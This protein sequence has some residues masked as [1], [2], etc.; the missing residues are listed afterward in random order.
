MQILRSIYPEKIENLENKVSEL[1][2]LNES[3]SGLKESFDHELERFKSLELSEVNLKL[4]NA[5]NHLRNKI[6][7]YITRLVKQQANQA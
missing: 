4:Q 2:D 3:L 5:L 7:G 1:T 6:A